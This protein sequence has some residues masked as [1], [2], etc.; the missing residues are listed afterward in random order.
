MPEEEAASFFEDVFNCLHGSGS[1]KLKA[2][3]STLPRSKA[4]KPAEPLKGCTASLSS[5]YFRYYER[6]LDLKG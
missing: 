4:I 3:S 1:A 2:S 5:C 6:L